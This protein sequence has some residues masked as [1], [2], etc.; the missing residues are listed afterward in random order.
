MPWNLKLKAFQAR[1]EEQ[2]KTKNNDKKLHNCKL[3]DKPDIN[4]YTSPNSKL[5][6]YITAALEDPQSLLLLRLFPKFNSYFG[7]KD[8]VLMY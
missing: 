2:N 7:Y 1:A 5:K 3:L 4:F 8:L 6:P